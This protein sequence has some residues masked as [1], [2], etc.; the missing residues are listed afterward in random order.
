MKRKLAVLGTAIMAAAAITALSLIH[1]QM[2]IR[3]SLSYVLFLTCKKCTNMEFMTMGGKYEKVY[4]SS[5]IHGN[6]S[7]PSDSVSYTH[8]DVYK[9][10]I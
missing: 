3:D 8:L 1:I 2:C 9:R 5:Y 4:S 6:G 10:Q 7:Q